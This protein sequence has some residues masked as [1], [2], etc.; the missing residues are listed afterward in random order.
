MRSSAD[1]AAPPR[2]PGALLPPARLAAGRRRRVA[3]DVLS[4]W[5]GLGGFQE[6]ASLR[7]WLYRI[8]TNR[9]LDAARSARRRPAKAWDVPNVELLEPTRR[10][11]VVWL[12]PY[13]D[14]L[15]AGGAEIPLGPEARYTQIEAVSLAFMTALQLLPP[16]Q[17]AVLVLRDVLGFPAREVAEMLDSTVE[18]VTSALKRARAGL[19]DQLPSDPRAGRPPQTGIP[20]RGRSGRRFAQAWEAADTDAVVALLTE[21][22]V[23]AM[24][25][26]PFGYDGRDVVAQ[27][28]GGLFDGGRRFDLV[29]Q[30][31][32]R[33]TGLRGLPP[34]PDRS[35]VPPSACTCC[36]LAGD[37]ITTLTRF[38]PTCSLGST[39][40]RRCRADPPISD[41]GP[42][43][44]S[45]ARGGSAFRRKALHL[46]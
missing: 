6:R 30:P 45:R 33:P 23:I 7:T 36:T 43:V 1:R 9:C 17:L 39:C 4:A 28:F 24:P 15:L 20:G 21:D 40:R 35:I 19:S 46:H 16:R 44:R 32:Q 8:A 10:D 12:E 29:A 31:G 22:A 34:H 38:D 41:R 18:S 42:N 37:R 26:M 27:F 5:R 3:G 13:P 11:E 25:P 2:A 14:S